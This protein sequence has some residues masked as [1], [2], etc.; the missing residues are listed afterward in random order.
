M[1]CQALFPQGAGG[2]KRTAPRVINVDQNAADSGAVRD[3]KKAGLLPD[4]CERRSVKYLN[5]IVEQDP[6]FIKR[7]VKPGL[8]FG[9]YPTVW[10]TIQGYEVMHMSRKGQIEGVEHGDCQAQNQFIAGLFGLTA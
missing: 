8:G 6:R 1:S 10:R 7:R 2:P 4:H 3:L 5:N 9:S